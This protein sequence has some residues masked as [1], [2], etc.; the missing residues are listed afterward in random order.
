MMRGRWVHTFVLLAVV[1]LSTSACGGGEGGA[2]E[3]GGERAA[4]RVIEH[5]MGETE[6]SGTPE[7]V[8]ALEFSYVDALASLG[9]TPV[10]IADDGDASRIIPQITSEIGDWT[11]VG[12]RAEPNL[13]KI[14]TLDP[15][16]IIADSARHEGVYDQLSEIAPTIVLNSFEG[17]YDETLDSFE[18]VGKA[19][20]QEQEM[21]KRLAEHEEKMEKIASKVPEDE[22]RKVLAAVAD[23]EYF[24]V[25]TPATYVPDVLTE[26]GLPYAMEEEEREAYLKIGLEQLTE[27]DP[28]VMFVMASGDTTVVDGWEKQEVW[29]NLSTVES[30]Q[31]YEVDRNLWARSRG[32]ISA[33]AI[34]EDALKLL[35]EK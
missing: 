24:S 12:A 27:I 13:E 33:E 29:R 34:A 10:G 1:L 25:H 21:E 16:L 17:G 22:D 31:V 15:D 6:I 14:A 32:V 8:V 23:A 3:N 28:D 26:I 2:S 5:E 11:S 35:Y 20:N 30:G 19:L 18:V 7:R 4:G 9:V